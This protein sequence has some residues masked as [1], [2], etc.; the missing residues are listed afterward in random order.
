MSEARK[1]LLERH[2]AEVVQGTQHQ[3]PQGGT[4]VT[5]ARTGVRLRCTIIPLV[6]SADVALAQPQIRNVF[7]VYFGFDPALTS[8]ALQ[9]LIFLTPPFAGKYVRLNGLPMAEGGRDWIYTV[10]CEERSEDQQNRP[11]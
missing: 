7:R 4:T 8:Q 3:N 9:R 11:A 2:Q 6:A 1:R 10:V 5:W